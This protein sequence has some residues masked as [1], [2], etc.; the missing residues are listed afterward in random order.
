MKKVTVHSGDPNRSPAKRT[1]LNGKA[2]EA[3]SPTESRLREEMK[4]MRAEMRMLRV[5]VTTLENI[6]KMQQAELAAFE[7]PA[8]ST[9]AHRR[10]L[11]SLRAQELKRLAFELQRQGVPNPI[12][13]ARDKLAKQYGLGSGQS[14]HKWLRRNR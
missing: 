9:R 11:A 3:S 7:N 14:F 10:T 12:S 6:I 4:W 2:R 1:G 5:Q 13:A 8:E